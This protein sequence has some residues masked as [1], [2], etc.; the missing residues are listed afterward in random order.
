MNR[1]RIRAE[2]PGFFGMFTQYRDFD[3]ES[4]DALEA[5]AG[6]LAAKGFQDPGGGR[7]IMPAAIV[8]IEQKRN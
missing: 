8:W 6:H 2:S 1:Y 4:S 5:F 3:L 7:W